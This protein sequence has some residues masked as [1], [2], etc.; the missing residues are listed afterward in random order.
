MCVSEMLK[1]GWHSRI[2][3]LTDVS[4]GGN[5]V[6]VM[7]TDEMSCVWGGVCV[8]VCVWCVYCTIRYTH[9]YG[10]VI[11]PIKEN[12]LSPE[13]LPESGSTA[14]PRQLWA[15]TV[16]HAA[17]VKIGPGG[18]RQW[19]WY[20]FII[21]PRGSVKLH[22]RA[23]SPNAPRA[24]P[25]RPSIPLRFVSRCEV[26]GDNRKLVQ[27]L[28]KHLCPFSPYRHP[29]MNPPFPTEAENKPDSIYD[30]FL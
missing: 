23:M 14:L 15:P 26:E 18:R 19:T 29:R 25:V 4:C 7:N 27:F 24:R 1:P 12:S 28:H 30:L 17:G 21:L 9:L 11:L 16:S 10:F 22:C 6:C 13:A 20:S 3:F 2:S 5:E 8:C